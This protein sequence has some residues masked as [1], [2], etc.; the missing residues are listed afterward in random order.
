MVRHGLKHIFQKPTPDIDSSDR[1][2]QLRSKTI[3]CGT[4][5][6]AETLAS[7]NNRVY[8]TYNG[9]YNVENQAGVSKLSASRTY[10]DLLS[11]TKG[12]V[13]LTQPPL[14]PSTDDYYQKNFAKGQMYEGNYNRFDPMINVS[15][16]CNDSVMVYDIGVTGFTGP[17][18]YNTNGGFIGATGP[19]SKEG[20]AFG[21]YL[22]TAVAVATGNEENNNRI[23]IDPNHCYYS[24]PCLQNASYTRFVTPNLTGL[25]GNAQFNAQ[26][27]INSDQYRCFNYPMPNIV[28]TKQLIPPTIEEIFNGVPQAVVITNIEFPNDQSTV[29]EIVEIEPRTPFY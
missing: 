15:N 11:I 2:Q 12:K 17:A 19:Q 7:G 28:L 8:K 5:N 25:T 4:V 16:D 1:T 3:Y 6:L 23:F 18:S 14:T 13:L 9:P 29:S 22:G 24:N 27:I 21:G 26:Q 20:V 10:E